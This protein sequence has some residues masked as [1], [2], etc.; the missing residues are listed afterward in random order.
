MD[1]S[2]ST[3]V[4][5]TPTST[6]RLVANA[7]HIIG[8]VFCV[9]S[10]Y[11]SYVMAERAI[12]VDYFAEW[13][14][15]TVGLIIANGSQLV[16]AILVRWVFKSDFYRPAMWVLLSI[17]MLALTLVTMVVAVLYAD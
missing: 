10:V 7:S 13:R 3:A 5:S 1:P 12:R 15:L 11:F 16:R 4:P 6:V 2:Q 17:N 9:L 8:V 14:L